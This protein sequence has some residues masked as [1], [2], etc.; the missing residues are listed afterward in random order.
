VAVGD[1]SSDLL[2]AEAGAATAGHVAAAA[3]WAWSPHGG[4]PAIHGV[5]RR[6]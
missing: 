5:V 6:L 1:G 4:A 3:P 2:R